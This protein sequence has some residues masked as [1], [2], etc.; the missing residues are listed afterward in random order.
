MVIFTLVFSF[1]I[2][3]ICFYI[4]FYELNNLEKKA[5]LLSHRQINGWEKSVKL[6]DV[7]L[8]EKEQEMIKR[9]MNFSKD[10]VMKNRLKFLQEQNRLIFKKEEGDLGEEMSLV[11]AVEVEEQDIDKILNIIDQSSKKGV[12]IFIRELSLAYDK[13]RLMLSKL[14]FTQRNL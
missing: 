7:V 5:N 14:I 12:R 11:N 1:I 2:A 3:S 4:K 8:K 13:D 10:E 9:Y 6:C